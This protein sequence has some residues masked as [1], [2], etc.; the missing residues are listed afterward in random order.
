[1]PLLAALLFAALLFAALL[2]LLLYMCCVN[3][4]P[5]AVYIYRCV[6]LTQCERLSSFFVSLTLLPHL[7][8]HSDL[9]LY[10]FVCLSLFN[11]SMRF[12]DCFFYFS[13]S[14]KLSLAMSDHL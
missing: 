5:D 8:L 1:M 2:Q 12:R 4:L 7:N 9:F 13:V 10:P 11:Y 14:D 3:V 6:F